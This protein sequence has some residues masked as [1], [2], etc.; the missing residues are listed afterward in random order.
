MKH[1]TVLIMSFVLALILVPGATALADQSAVARWNDCVA[2]LPGLPSITSEGKQDDIGGVLAAMS[3]PYRSITS[4]ELQ[5]DVFLDKLCALFIASGSAGGRDAAPHLARWVERGG[6]LYVSGFALDVLLD[7]FPGHLQLTSSGQAPS[8]LTQVKV[9]TEAETALGRDLWIQTSGGAWPQVEK[10]KLEARI[11]AYARLPSGDV[12]VIFSFN[13]GPGWVVYNVLN[14][15]NDTADAQQRL[16][17]FF[18]VRTLFARDATSTLQR[19]PAAYD[20]PTLIA[21]TLKPSNEFSYTARSGDDWDAVLVW[22]G[23]TRSMTL[24]S[25]ISTTVTQQSANMPLIMPVRNGAGGNWQ[26]TVSGVDASSANLPFL[27]M[28]IPRRGTNLLNAVPVPSQVST[29]A[30]VIGSN[31]GL[32][33]AMAVLLMLS[34]SLFAGRKSTSNRLWVATGKAAGQVSGALGSLFAPTT[35]PVPPLCLLYTSP[36]PRD[37]S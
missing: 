33:L 21:D 36:S 20:A 7:A 13:A 17:R 8:G 18:V 25:P 29:D 5:D 14:A 24:A 12:P 35:W 28:L 9:D 34:A 4:A 6:S 23:G 22:N 15:G 26:M 19:F 32:A 37:C 2:V 1:N 11:H 30:A 10:G 31:V 27:L 3:I 16:V